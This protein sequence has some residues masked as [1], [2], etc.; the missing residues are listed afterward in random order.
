MFG[1]KRQY[2]VRRGDVE[3]AARL[4]HGRRL[5]LFRHRPQRLCIAA[6]QGY[7]VIASVIAVGGFTQVVSFDP[8]LRCH[9]EE[10][11]VRNRQAGEGLEPL[12]RGIQA[13]RQHTVAVVD[14]A[15]GHKKLAG[16]CDARVAPA[17]VVLPSRV[18]PGDLARCSVDKQRPGPA[19]RNDERGA[20]EGQRTLR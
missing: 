8:V 16:G 14:V 15:V 3:P 2:L 7:T 5:C 20:V 9:V 1:R 10:L 12:G 11:A 6:D 13:Q 4:D 19:G 18:G 17:A